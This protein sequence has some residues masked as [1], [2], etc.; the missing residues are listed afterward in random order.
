MLDRWGLCSLEP[1]AG[2]LGEERQERHGIAQ[3][4]PELR[5]AL[6]GADRARM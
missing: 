1:P 3:M 6:S 2:A 5:S 4:L